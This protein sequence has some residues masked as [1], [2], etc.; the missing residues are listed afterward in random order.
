[1]ERRM[2][3]GSATAAA[4]GRIG[5]YSPHWNTWSD[6]IWDF[7]EK[8]EPGAFGRK[9]ESFDGVVS[10]FNHDVGHVLGRSPGTLTVEEDET[11]LRYEVEPPD[12]KV[13]TL[14]QRGDVTGA[15]FGFS[16]AEDSWSTNADGIMERIVHSAVLHDVGPV[17]FAAY[18][19]STAFARDAL[20][21]LSR[22]EDQHG[23]FHAQALQVPRDVVSSATEARTLAERLGYRGGRLAETEDGPYVI[24]LRAPD[25][26]ASRR[27]VPVPS[28]DLDRA[29]IRG[30][31]LVGGVLPAE[32]AAAAESLDSAFLELAHEEQML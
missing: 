16:A 25:E 17:V 3:D 19:T 26:F 20:R 24:T 7:R 30:V 14:V 22:W 15:S 12:D 10:L 6:L 1:M 9:M 32:S 2:A 11:G 23:G 5:G 8:F 18:P 27:R 13:L 21:S 29:Q 4:T 28:S 31:R